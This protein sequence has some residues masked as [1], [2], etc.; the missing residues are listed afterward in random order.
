MVCEQCGGASEAAPEYAGM[1]MECPH[2]TAHNEAG[3]APTS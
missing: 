2:C 3:P 1:L